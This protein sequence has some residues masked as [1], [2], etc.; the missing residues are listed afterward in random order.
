MTD[1]SKEVD[2]KATRTM[3]NEEGTFMS[4]SSFMHVE[5]FV[6]AEGGKND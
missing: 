2:R 5:L 6:I 1:I 3:A 4:S